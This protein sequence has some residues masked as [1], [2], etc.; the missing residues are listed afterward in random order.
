MC[1]PAQN[2]QQSKILNL[3]DNDE[4]CRTSHNLIKTTVF[5]PYYSLFRTNFKEMQQST[6]VI[7]SIYTILRLCARYRNTSNILARHQI[8]CTFWLVI[9]LIALNIIEK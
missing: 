1:C 6:I 2:R 7:Q 3:I 5:H 8:D 4:S 9:K